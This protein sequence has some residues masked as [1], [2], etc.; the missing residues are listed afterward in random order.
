MTYLEV[1]SV[2]AHGIPTTEYRVAPTRELLLITIEFTPCVHP[3]DEYCYP[4]PEFTFGDEVATVEQW[5]DC[6]E[7]NLNLDEEID[8]Y[9]V[10]A[11]EL[12]EN[13]TKSGRLRETPHWLYGIRCTTGTKELMWFEGAELVAKRDLKAG[14]REF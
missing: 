14:D 5:S 11:L 1:Q 10:C 8:I 4:H 12:V 6:Q 2:E 7:H 3:A 9:K 13:K